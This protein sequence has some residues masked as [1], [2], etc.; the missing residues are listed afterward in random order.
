MV[1]W[2]Y[3]IFMEMAKNNKEKAKDDGKAHIYGN[4]TR[5]RKP[6]YINKQSYL[7]LIKKKIG[8]VRERRYIS[9]GQVRSLTRVSVFLKANQI[10]IWLIMELSQG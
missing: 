5:F 1:G 4:L 10:F 2:I 3:N 7:T 6:Q 8:K 9:R